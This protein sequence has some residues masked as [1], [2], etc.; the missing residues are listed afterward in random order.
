MYATSLFKYCSLDQFWLNYLVLWFCVCAELDE[1][2]CAMPMCANQCPTGYALDKNGCMTCRCKPPSCEVSHTP[3]RGQI[4]SWCSSCNV[5]SS[6][7]HSSPLC[8]WKCS[9]NVVVYLQES[10]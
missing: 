7:V 5:I 8:V 1:M 6:E 2:P 4:L 9:L 3:A 10:L